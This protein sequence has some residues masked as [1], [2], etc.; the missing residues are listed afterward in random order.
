M[1]LV[2]GLETSPPALCTLHHG[3]ASETAAAHSVGLQAQS[4]IDKRRE[5][6]ETAAVS[7]AGEP[8]G[9]RWRKTGA[10]Q[11]RTWLLFHFLAVA[12]AAAVLVL[13]CFR[14]LS[15]AS[16]FWPV[17]RRLSSGGM[18]PRV[19]GSQGDS[20]RDA[21]EEPDEAAAGSGS[22]SDSSSEGTGVGD[23]TSASPSSEEE[24]GEAFEGPG[25]EETSQVALGAPRALRRQQLRLSTATTTAGLAVSTAAVLLLHPLLPSGLWMALDSHPWVAAALRVGFVVGVLSHTEDQ[26]SGFGSLR[27][28]LLGAHMEL[29]AV[30]L[31]LGRIHPLGAVSLAGQLG[32][33]AA[34]F[35]LVLATQAFYMWEVQRRRLT[36]RTLLQSLLPSEDPDAPMP[37]HIWRSIGVLAIVSGLVS[38]ASAFGMGDNLFLQALLVYSGCIQFTAGVEQLTQT[39]EGDAALD[40]ATRD[41]HNQAQ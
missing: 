39:Q 14:H 27:R 2:A 20:E 6:V 17:T 24:Q 31:M 33:A 36:S 28:I 26:L 35:M 18:Q 21:R 13:Q 10:V 22:G 41:R 37:D 30:A 11:R 7:S 3:A 25:G 15:A 23:S 32:A 16:A 5:Q 8:S 4:R 34:F 12:A 38:V 29:L 19:C 40:E 1:A 9:N